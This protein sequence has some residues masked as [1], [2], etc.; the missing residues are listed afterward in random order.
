MGAV[1][2]QVSGDVSLRPRERSTIVA[3]PSWCASLLSSAAS[4]TRKNKDRLQYA[5]EKSSGHVGKEIG[6]RQLSGF[7]TRREAS[8]DPYREALFVSRGP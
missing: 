3:P 7:H 5:V 4:R 1:V 8:F 6:S 2:L